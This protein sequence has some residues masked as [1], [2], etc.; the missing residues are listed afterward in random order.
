[1]DMNRNR[2]VI[3]DKVIF[4]IAMFLFSFFVIA[5]ETIYF[6]MLLIVT[7]YI[8]ATF[9]ITVALF[10]IA[11]GS[12]IAFYLIDFKKEAVI[13]ITSVLFI[14]SIVLSYYNITHIGQL[15][16]PI[17]LVL[18]F[19][20]SS[21]IISTI[22][23]YGHSNTLYFTNL[24][25]SALGVFYPIIM[26]PLIKSENAIFALILLPA[27]FLIIFAFKFRNIVMTLITLALGIMF[28]WGTIDFLQE[29]LSFPEQF[30][31]Q[32]W[33]E[34]VLEKAKARGK[35]LGTYHDLDFLSESYHY[36][37]EKDAY[38]FD[39]DEID[40]QHAKYLL[41]Q[42]EVI[43]FKDLFFDVK[44]HYS[45]DENMKTL[46]KDWTI[47]VA[48]DSTMGRADIFD[49]GSSL[50]M[51]INGVALDTME[52]SNGTSYDPRVPHLDGADIFIIGLSADGIVKSS[53][54][55]KNAT[56]E[57]V[58]IN[59]TIK[60]IMQPDNQIAQYANYPYINT[61]E[62]S[63]E[64]RGFLSTTDKQY[65]MITL[66]N[67]HMEHG[68]ICTYAPE[69]F[70]T[71][72]S[73]QLLLD[74]LS[75]RGMIVYEEIISTPRSQYAFYKFMNTI[76]AA[77]EEKGYEN[78]AD[79]VAIFHWDFWG[80]KMFRTV[81]VKPRPYTKEELND[82]YRYYNVIKSL[83]YYQKVGLITIPDKTLGTIPE[84]ILR[85]KDLPEKLVS[86]PYGV[87][88][89]EYLHDFVN[90]LH[91]TSDITFAIDAYR[92]AGGGYY[93]RKYLSPR[94]RKRLEDLMYKTGYLSELDLKPTTDDRPY[95]YD[96]YKEKTEI[97]NLLNIVFVMIAI[98]LVPVLLRIVKNVEEHGIRILPQTLYYG[99]LG[100]SYMLVEIVLIQKF[101][102]F[103]GNPTYSIIVILGGM[104]LFSGLGSFV[105]MKFNK[106]VLIGCMLIIPLILL[107]FNF[108]LDSI[109]V[110]FGRASFTA[111]LWI[112]VLLIFP[113]TFFMGMPFPHTL[114]VVKEQ[115]SNEYGTLMFGI[116][117]IAGTAAVTLA[118]YTNIMYG[119]STTFVIGTVGY[120]I[121]IALFMVLFAR[122]I[123]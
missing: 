89:S 115:A 75:D 81:I 104:L 35:K 123:K 79:H 76:K 112:S 14:G 54:K 52:N 46:K 44:D 85:G 87:R 43:K 73:I 9:I 63:G 30:S 92:P 34:T 15:Q 19:L 31:K 102:N 106:K 41:A 51:S 118:V 26:L 82:F 100:F 17:F 94:K 113:L 49:T 7:N 98:F 119:F 22:F 80:G 18:P 16:Y 38:V 88:Y 91:T 36:D 70:H 47:V 45:L 97:L 86:A 74:K 95:P 2:F 59:P 110:L 77:L 116:S 60:K 5:S 114:E 56:V 28:T 6:H 8:N 21:I 1:M 20:L 69:N 107:I 40:K 120:L 25:A 90:K 57:G 78:P 29:N 10:G 13:L 93:I 37:K 96:V 33:E 105:S 23:S 11:A 53:K 84:K 66:M 67:I 68:P 27:V 12:F 99:T 83:S 39:G 72:E 101:Q 3:S 117:G 111:K 50:I 65:D 121:G 42:M 64:G 32:T 55:I 122:H 103:I 4:F 24:V 71:V 109:F 58:E 62:H 48:E 108:Q 61:I